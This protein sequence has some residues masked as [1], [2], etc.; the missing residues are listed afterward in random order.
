MQYH[1]QPTL[2]TVMAVP[3]RF[4]VQ[5]LTFSSHSGIPGVRSHS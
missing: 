2:S 3:A 4:S 1:I 5:M